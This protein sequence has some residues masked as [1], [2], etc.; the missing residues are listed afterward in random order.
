MIYYMI[1]F[2]KKNM[3]TLSKK[4]GLENQYVKNTFIYTRAKVGTHL[5][6]LLEEGKENSIIIGITHAKSIGNNIQTVGCEFDSLCTSSGISIDNSK[7]LKTAKE[8]RAI[9]T[10]VDNKTMQYKNQKILNHLKYSTGLSNKFEQEKLKEKI[11]LEN[12]ITF[13]SNEYNSEKTYIL[14]QT[15][16]KT[17]A[18]DIKN[19][20]K[21][22]NLIGDKMYSNHIAPMLDLV[23]KL[24]EEKL[25]I[26]HILKNEINNQ[27][28]SGLFKIIQ[29]IT[30]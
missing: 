26:A 9:L 29:K 16:T 30:S 27:G 7:V 25:G 8:S 3:K 17:E 21:I 5:G 28:I 14:Y 20:V 6:L 24:G 23:E 15:K 2:Q 4:I 19:E 10:I 1:T 18:I 11:L 12:K 13:L 22:R